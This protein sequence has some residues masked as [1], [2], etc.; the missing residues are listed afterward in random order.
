MREIRSLTVMVAWLVYA[1]ACNDG[2]SSQGST[3]REANVESLT[4]EGQVDGQLSP[5]V[6]NLLRLRAAGHR[7]GG[8]IDRVLSSIL[9]YQ[10]SHWNTS[11]P[12]LSIYD[13]FLDSGIVEIDCRRIVL[14]PFGTTL[15][16][17]EPDKRWIPE[18]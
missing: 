12:D 4:V 16:Y 2:Q 8:K 5:V 6:V 10:C 7:E 13:S 1:G 11:A 18:S 15:D 3:T 9:D 14:G 17:R